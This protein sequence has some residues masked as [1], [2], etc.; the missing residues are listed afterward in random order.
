MLSPF[1][2]PVDAGDMGRGR[3]LS[4]DDLTADAQVEV[5]RVIRLYAMNK[6]LYKGM[7][8]KHGRSKAD[9]GKKLDLLECQVRPGVCRQT[10]R[11]RE[12]LTT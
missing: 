7:A 6:L 11:H 5:Y 3:I 8:K 10:L 9:V 4:E 1:L 2:E 12:A